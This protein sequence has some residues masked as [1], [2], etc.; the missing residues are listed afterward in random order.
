M[1]HLRVRSFVLCRA[2]AIYLPSSKPPM[3]HLNF[4]LGAC[5]VLGTPATVAVPFPAA[6][7]VDFAVNCR[8]SPIICTLT[9]RG[10]HG[11]VHEMARINHDQTPSKYFLTGPHWRARDT[12]FAQN[13]TN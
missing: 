11:H 9:N 4:A 8:S 13:L 5:R 3:Q 1:S 7:M 2:P 12:F 10:R 6:A